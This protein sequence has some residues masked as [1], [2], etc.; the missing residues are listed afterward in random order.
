MATCRICNEPS[1][2]ILCSIGCEIVM[3]VTGVRV[4]EQVNKF[5]EI[6]GNKVTRPCKESECNVIV[7]HPLQFCAECKA[8]RVASQKKA[9]RSKTIKKTIYCNTCKKKI[10]KPTS[11]SVKY[12]D[13]VCRPR[14]QV[15]AKSLASGE[16]EPIRKQNKLSVNPK[17]TNPRGSKKRKEMGLPELRYATGKDGGYST[18]D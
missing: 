9:Y 10:E 7:E 16:R 18:V 17:F 8:K 2:S 4:L 1:N 12:C 11:N 15:T 5:K 6:T 13:D 14:K 3:E